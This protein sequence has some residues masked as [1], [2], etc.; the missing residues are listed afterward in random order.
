MSQI[1]PSRQTI[2]LIKQFDAKKQHKYVYVPTSRICSEN[3]FILVNFSFLVKKFSSLHKFYLHP[4]DISVQKFCPKHKLS[5]S[6]WEPQKLPFK[7]FLLRSFH[8]FVLHYFVACVNRV[9]VCFLC[10]PNGLFGDFFGFFGN[11]GAFVIF[12][13]RN[14]SL[15]IVDQFTMITIC[16]IS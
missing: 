4:S 14:V 8:P 16:R 5:I 9:I 1:A 2:N 7:H 3:V 12:R 10:W 13:V 11:F 15:Y 6:A